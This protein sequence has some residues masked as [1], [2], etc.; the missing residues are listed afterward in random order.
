MYISNIRIQNFRLIKDACLHLDSEKK[1]EL[2]LLLGRNNSG[3]TSFIIL[4]EKFLNT[5]RFNF[6]DF[7]LDLRD[8]ILNI[9]SDTDIDKLSIRLILEICYTEDDSLENIS[10]LILDLDPE[11]NTVNLLFECSINK[12]KL[13]ENLSNI[14]ERK[15]EHIQKFIKNFLD[16][17]VYTFNEISDIE[18]K[19]RG[20]LIE[21]DRK[22]IDKLINLQIIHAKRNVASS[23]SRQNEKK[24]LSSLAT[25]YYNRDNKASQNKLNKINK[26]IFEMDGTLNK[27]YSTYFDDFLE[28]AREFLGIQDL[29]VIS[30]LESKEI[31]ANHSKIVYGT[32]KNH[33]PEHLNGL[34]YMNILYLLLRIKIK[35]TNFIEENKDINLLFIEEPEAHTHPQMQYVFIEKIKDT[36]KKI[37][38]LQTIISTHS[39]HIVK[40]CNFEDIR[41]FLSKDNDT[42]IEIKNF[43]NELKEKYKSE[44]KEK[45]EAE[46]ANFNF[47]KQYLTISSAELFFAEKIIFIEGTT[48]KLLLPYFIQKFDEE[49]MKKNDENYTPLS[50]QNVSVLEVGANSRAFRHFIALLEIKTLIITDIDTTKIRFIPN[51]KDPSKSK[52]TTPACEVTEGLFTSNYSIKY[53]LNCP[54]GDKEIRE[55][56]KK[57]KANELHDESSLIK[58]AYQIKENGYH[59]RSFEDAFI[60]SNIEKIKTHRNEINGLKNRDKL[61]SFTNFYTLTEG[62]LAGKSGLASS[63]LWLVLS[64][65]DLEWDIPL[66]IK[67]GLA[68]ITE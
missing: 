60:S 12:K 4:F 63:L 47:L 61:D 62:I 20:N 24:V 55:W 36:L 25:A 29:R 21:K 39:A 65:N 1:K 7:S 17:T 3:K 67:E 33:L 13:L 32:A 16:V 2:S 27:D 26:S 48:E 68:W 59:G 52:T 30:D 50:S 11:V 37:N 9:N 5:H 28:S 58:V 46:K 45:N 14:S 10:D 44:D 23:E 22:T 56:M 34:G 43:Y 66:Y 41:Y 51:K 57:L 53:F 54:K 31:I 64:K 19:N 15:H 6:N 40:K 49:Q 18:N 38:N 42:N 35:K 8:E